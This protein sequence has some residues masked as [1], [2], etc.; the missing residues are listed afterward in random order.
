[1][2]LAICKG[3]PKHPHD[4]IAVTANLHGGFIC[5]ACEAIEYVAELAQELEQRTDELRAARSR[6]VQ[7]EN[8][9]ATQRV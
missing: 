5:P 6:I 8:L 4:T 1:M 9:R 7:L 3:N 2:S